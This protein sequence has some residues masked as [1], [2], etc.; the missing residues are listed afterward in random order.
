MFDL[1]LRPTSCSPITSTRRSESFTNSLPLYMSLCTSLSLDRRDS[2]IFAFNSPT[3][4]D[5]DRLSNVS[6]SSTPSDERILSFSFRIGG[7]VPSPVAEPEARSD[8]EAV[9][10]IAESLALAHARRMFVTGCQ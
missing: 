5:G 4:V 9:G 10:S 8:V 2:R 3:V 7:L 1:F 6:G